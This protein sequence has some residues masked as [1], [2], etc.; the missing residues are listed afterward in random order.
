VRWLTARALSRYR[1]RMSGE[2]SPSSTAAIGR[3]VIVVGSSCSGKS[4]VGARLAEL[5]TA[6]FV[7]LDAL[8][9][10]PNWVGSEDEEFQQKIREATAGDSWVVAGGYS[11]H[12][13]PT[14]WPRAD[15]IV[16]LDFPL[17][18]SVWRII[19]R[20]WRRSRSNELL[21]GTNYEKFWPQFKLW[22]DESLI[23]FTV[24]NHR[25]RGRGYTAAMDNPR[26]LQ[27]TWVRLRNQHEV[28]KWLAGMEA[29]VSEP[30]VAGHPPAP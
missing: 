15:M 6:P 5:L 12:T 17:R 8:Y 3:R 30:L 25:R 4:T 24:K 14:I 29:A 22:G 10:K 13:V 27:V 19:R 1:I 20:S 28:D 2:I 26:L 23:T 16:W 21:W 18:T 9:W 11:R 7:E